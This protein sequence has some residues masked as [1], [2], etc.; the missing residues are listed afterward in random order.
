MGAGMGFM[1]LPF[2]KDEGAATAFDN[3][4][5]ERFTWSFTHIEVA[6]GNAITRKAIDDNL[7]K[8]QFN[9]TNLGLIKSFKQTKEIIAADVFTQAD[10]TLYCSI[11]FA[12]WSGI[13]IPA[14]CGYL[15][16]WWKEV[17]ERPSAKA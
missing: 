5:G 1:G 3:A 4:A 12:G 17:S 7:Y 2:L 15:Q 6:L 16:R 8:A 14:D 10:C 11:E 9:P 13:T